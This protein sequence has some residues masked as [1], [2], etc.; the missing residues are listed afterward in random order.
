M[1]AYRRPNDL[2]IESPV[3]RH[4]DNPY[5]NNGPTKRLIFIELPS[6]LG[7]VASTELEREIRQLALVL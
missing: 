2:R 5:T 7:S 6:L 1:L 3:Q 4:P